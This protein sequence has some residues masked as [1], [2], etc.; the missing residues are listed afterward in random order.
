MSR[1]NAKPTA[2][3]SVS[4]TNAAGNAVIAIPPMANREAIR[5]SA[6]E[7]TISKTLGADR[8]KCRRSRIDRR[9]APKHQCCEGQRLGRLH[10]DIQYKNAD[11]KD[12]GAKGQQANSHHNSSNC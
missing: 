9:L 1:T 7:E 5:I 3:A 10:V 2:A 8:Q 11:A 6:A 12:G 4:A